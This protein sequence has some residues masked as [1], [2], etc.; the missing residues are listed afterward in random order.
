[1]M[2]ILS[3]FISCR[4]VERV[5]SSTPTPRIHKHCVHTQSHLGYRSAAWELLGAKCLAQGHLDHG[6]EAQDEH[7]QNKNS[8][9]KSD[10]IANNFEKDEV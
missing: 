5:F 7:V 8:F 9:E 3:T 2:I 1:M 10:F 4:F 6:N